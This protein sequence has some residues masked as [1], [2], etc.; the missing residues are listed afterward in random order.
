MPY[1][2]TLWNDEK[3]ALAKSIIDK[4]PVGARVEI[5]EE[6]RTTEQNKKLW[7]SLTE[8]SLQCRH[9]GLRL[10]PDD[11]KLLFLDQLNSEMR[12]VPNLDGDGFVNL[13]K[14]SSKLSKA[15]FSALI[16]LILAYGAKHGVKFND[17]EAA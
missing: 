6:K 14:S 2:F 4:A 15:E 16:E 8:I 5:S 12:L 11:W 9:H 17:A 3:R 10:S 13:G 7:P 1:R